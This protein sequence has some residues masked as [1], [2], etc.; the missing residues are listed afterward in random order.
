VTRA[1]AAEGCTGGP[2][3]LPR[4]CALWRKAIV[5][6]YCVRIFGARSVIVLACLIL[7]AACHIQLVSDYDEEFVKTASDIQKEIDTLLQN[8]RN[9]PKGAD[10][11][12]EANK[13]AYNKIEV[14]LSSLLALAQSHENNDPSIDQVK[15]LIETV[16]RLEAIHERDNRVPS[17]AI[18]IE[19]N[20]IRTQIS[21]IVRT[22]NAKKAGR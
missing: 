14:E 6:S 11:S 1:A 7:V 8:Q 21:S 18:N 13:P 2:A 15:A 9:P 19:Q 16:H 10:L 5:R 17:A 20:T 22:E 4:R 12:Y 3:P